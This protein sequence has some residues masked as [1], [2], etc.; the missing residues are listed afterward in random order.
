MS[1]RRSRSKDQIA[2]L[3][4]RRHDLDL[5]VARGPRDLARDL[6][7]GSRRPHEPHPAC[8]PLSGWDGPREFSTS[9]FAPLNSP[10]CLVPP[11]FPS[12]HPHPSP[13]CLP[14]FSCGMTP[15]R[16]VLPGSPIARLLGWSKSWDQ[17]ETPLVAKLCAR[18]Q[19]E[20]V[21]PH[22]ISDYGRKRCACLLSRWTCDSAGSYILAAA[23]P[24]PQSARLLLPTVVRVVGQL[25][26]LRYSLAG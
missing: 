3:L 2:Q 26:Q 4:A 19:P 7:Q 9:L 6:H 8:C 18:T 24:L 15:S 22:Q 14:R 1:I 25:Q 21:S 20:H 12:P 23:V 10:Y 11:L 5:A 17:D 13:S 16:L